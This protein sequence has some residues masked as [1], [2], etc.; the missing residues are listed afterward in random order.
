MKTHWIIQEFSNPTA[1]SEQLLINYLNSIDRPV[2]TFKYIP[3]GATDFSFL[4]TIQ[5]P[6]VFFGTW[7][8][9][10]DLKNR[11]ISYPKPFAWCDLELFNCSTYYAK[12][13][14][15]ILQED[16][17]FYKL[18]D[19]DKDWLYKNDQDLFIRPNDN[20]K[21]FTGTVI[22]KNRFDFWRYQLHDI[23]KVPKDLLVVTAK[24]KRIHSEWRLVIV[25]GKVAGSSLYKH[26]WGINI[27]PGCP[28]EV[29][30]FAEKVASQWSP[31]PV[32]IMD[33]GSI[34]NTYKVIEIGP[35]NYAGL[36]ACDI[37]KIVDAINNLLE[38]ENAT[39]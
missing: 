15:F 35:F 12:L 16:I 37:K 29:T 4:Q 38:K 17:Y 25:D 10:N 1:S 22:G 7:N 13:H 20:E 11:N 21:S 9:L 5:E 36:Y 14:Q 23:Y 34:N 8:V 30:D 31:H 32:Y 27:Q 19:I 28:Q 3:F 39:R 6:A 2:T 33:V 24:T 18:E 26:S